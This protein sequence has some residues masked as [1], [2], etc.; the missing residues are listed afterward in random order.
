LETSRPLSGGVA[1]RSKCSL[2]F[3]TSRANKTQ[4][5]NKTTANNNNA[6]GA[7]EAFPTQTACCKQKGG[8]GYSGGPGGRECWAPD[9][10]AKKCVKSR[11]DEPNVNCSTG[12]AGGYQYGRICE[13][14]EFPGAAAAAAS[15]AA[16]NKMAPK[17][18][19]QQQ[20]AMMQGDKMAPKPAAMMQDKMA[21]KPA[22]MQ[23][24]MA[25]KPA[26]Q[27]QQPATTTAAAQGGAGAPRPRLISINYTG[28]SDVDAAGDVH[29]P[30]GG[31]PFTK[32]C[33]G[34]ANVIV[35]CNQTEGCA[36]FALESKDVA[37]P[38][39]CGY[40]KRAGGKTMARKGWSVYV[41]S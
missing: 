25:P 7:P 9:F 16:G 39:A 28:K 15:A 40:L 32:V 23:D 11:L 18:A 29:I 13:A 35:T 19:M 33:G 24:K 37:N 5:Q 30:S 31:K 4:K 17:P 21:P 2:P 3:W 27:Q 10:A 34:V 12:L 14:E 20:P 41:R 1:L 38:A 22:A 26:M 8:C 6:V 36:A